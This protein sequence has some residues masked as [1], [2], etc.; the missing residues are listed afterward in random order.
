MDWK[1]D[2]FLSKNTKDYNEVRQLL[3]FLENAGLRVFESQKSLP[4]LGLADYA[5]AIDNAIE[6]SQNLIVLCSANE[7]GTGEGRNSRW[8]YYE[9]TLFRN[10][11]LSKRKNGSLLTVLCNDINVNMLPV[12]L[13]KYQT[14]ELDNIEESGILDYIKN[15]EEVNSV[16]NDLSFDKKNTVAIDLKMFD[17]GYHFSICMFVKMQNKQNDNIFNMLQ[18]DIDELDGISWKDPFQMLLESPEKI[19]KEL[20]ALYGN[21]A[22]DIFSLGQYCGISVSMALF[23]ILGAE[24]VFKKLQSIFIPY[25][26]IADSLGIPQSVIEN[27]ITMIEDKDQERIT[28]YYKLVRRA[29]AIRNE[30]SMKCP[31]C[32]A[33][34]AIGSEK[35]Y[36]CMNTLK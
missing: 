19:V 25:I 34:T 5:Q 30:T 31:Y 2:V 23:V 11:L 28:N 16:N 22:G 15:K 8:V 29:V 1:Y 10:E 21:V 4:K 26:R 3:T 35:C 36:N 13:R 12:G 17:F 6:L 32:G 24:D 20:K 14:F 33:I 27:L 18:E 9:W 7:L